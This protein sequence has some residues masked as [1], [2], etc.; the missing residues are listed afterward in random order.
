MEFEGAE[1]FRSRFL[2]LISSG[3][4]IVSVSLAQIFDDGAWEVYGCAKICEARVQKRPLPIIVN[5]CQILKVQIFLLE[6]I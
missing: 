6:K 5:Y 4:S 2:P 1:V 3:V